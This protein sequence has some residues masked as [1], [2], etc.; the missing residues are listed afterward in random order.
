MLDYPTLEIAVRCDLELIELENHY[1]SLF[2]NNLGGVAAPPFAGCFLDKADRLGFM[3]RFSG[4]CREHGVV[5]D[6]THPPDYIPMMMEAL[7]LLVNN[8]NEQGSL[9]PVI[10][11]FY[12]CW[13]ERF[14]AA[15]QQSDTVGIYATVA[16]E[17]CQIL[18]EIT[19][20][21][22]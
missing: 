6:T 3:A 13:P 14:A 1:I 5:V 9:D 10:T 17:F 15:L 8:E 16:E 18:H 12:S 11:E 2:A 4:F 7:A 21:E 22:N 19:G 20:H